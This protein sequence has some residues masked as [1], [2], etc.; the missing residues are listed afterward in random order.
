M[1]AEVRQNIEDR[2]SEW[3]LKLQ[4]Y[5]NNNA[6]SIQEAKDIIH[7]GLVDITSDLI[8]QLNT[9]INEYLEDAPDYI[10]QALEEDI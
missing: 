1:V 10:K 2:K 8:N 9:D 4:L 6:D 3:Y 5:A 7:K